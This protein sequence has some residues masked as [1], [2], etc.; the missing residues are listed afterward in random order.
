MRM[1]SSRAPGSESWSAEGS[2]KDRIARKDAIIQEMRERNRTLEV[3]LVKHG[4]QM[5]DCK[6][7]NR[8]LS[9]RTKEQS[10]MGTMMR[11]ESADRILQLQKVAS[12]ENVVD[13]GD[14]GRRHTVEET[15]STKTEEI[16][17]LRA[18]LAACEL[19]LRKERSKASNLAAR[20]AMLESI[21][22][23]TASQTTKEKADITSGLEQH[24]EVA[25][26][27]AAMVQR[28]NEQYGEMLRRMGAIGDTFSIC[29]THVW[30]FSG[31]FD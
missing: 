27:N 3:T 14:V 23:N 10:Y 2:L 1:G 30:A 31:A 26:R 12:L 16:E 8:K 6:K 5:D 24:L 18:E 11:R 28:Q 17:L 21:A 4:E 13:W 20:V 15:L 22:E 25:D 19:K 9:R 7:L 29:H